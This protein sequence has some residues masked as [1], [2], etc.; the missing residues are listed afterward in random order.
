MADA[1]ILL[2]QLQLYDSCMQPD[3]LQAIRQDN[4]ER[5]QGE[6]RE[7]I[8]LSDDNDNE[9]IDADTAEVSTSAI[10][11]T[12]PVC[13][14]AKLELNDGLDDRARSATTL[15]SSSHGAV[16]NADTTN[17]SHM[18]T[19]GNSATV[20]CDDT[21]TSQHTTK[22][23]AVDNVSALNCQSEQIETTDATMAASV[24]AAL[25]DTT[26]DSDGLIVSVSAGIGAET[27]K[28]QHDSSISTSLNE[29]L[30]QTV[31]TSD[32]LTDATAAADR[33]SSYAAHATLESNDTRQRHNSAAINT[34][35]VDTSIDTNQNV[36]MTSSQSD[37]TRSSLHD[38]QYVHEVAAN[39]S[40]QCNNSIAG[41]SSDGITAANKVRIV[42]T[43]AQ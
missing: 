30:S 14:R 39:S 16:S 35:Q 17:D 25:A 22:L 28:R 8:L 36:A 38:D 32:A 7:V 24:E 5:R 23:M 1:L 34:T 11:G 31:Q 19:D 10:A 21:N 6:L 12:E 15:D 13:K 29:D 26:A 42:D 27:S 20:E 3:W 43:L 4:T 18:I 2:K 41:S 9:I 33:Q 40:Y 37:N